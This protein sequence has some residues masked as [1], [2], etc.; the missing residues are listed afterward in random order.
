ML[1]NPQKNNPLPVKST[2]RGFVYSMI[3]CTTLL[4]KGQTQI[5]AI[6]TLGGGG[7]CGK[8]AVVGGATYSRKNLAEELCQ[9]VGLECQLHTIGG[10]FAIN[11]KGGEFAQL[12]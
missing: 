6:D 4:H 8:G 7:K 5:H 2:S 11:L 1:H 12:C 9:L 10:H 3:V